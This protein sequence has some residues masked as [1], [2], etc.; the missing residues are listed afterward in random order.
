MY[1]AA[2]QGPSRSG[3]GALPSLDTRRTPVPCFQTRA[4]ASGLWNKAAAV[5]HG[6]PERDRL[7][8]PATGLAGA[9]RVLHPRDPHLHERYKRRDVEHLAHEA[10]GP[11]GQGGYLVQPPHHRQRSCQAGLQLRRPHLPRGTNERWSSPTQV[12][13]TARAGQD[14]YIGK[15]L[16]SGQGINNTG[17][18]VC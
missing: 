18:E 10:A 16:Y 13:G 9:S 7:D 6:R 14:T 11:V 2:S 1:G 4:N 8:R 15:V 3:L 17:R 12:V 5:C